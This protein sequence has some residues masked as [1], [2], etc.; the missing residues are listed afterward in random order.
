MDELARYYTQDKISQLLINKLENHSPKRI[1]ELG[2]GD[3]ALS[4]AAYK[5]WKKAQYFGIDIDEDSIASIKSKLPFI[6]IKKINGLDDDLQIK[7]D[8]ENSSID[9]AICNP[10]YL[11]H[12]E[13]VQDN[14][15]FEVTLLN[16][17]IT[18]KY[19]TTD[20]IFLAQNLQ[21]LKEGSELGII[22]PDSILTNQY[23]AELRK[24]LLFHHNVKCIIQLPDKV[25]NKTEAR[26]HILIIQKF[27]QG[28]SKIE[29]CNTDHNGIITDHIYVE[30]DKLIKRMDYSFWKYINYV[31]KR[32][33]IILEEIMSSL[34]RGNKTKK[35][36]QDM[37]INFFHTTSFSKYDN[38]ITTNSR[39]I[40]FKE[41]LTLAENGDILIARVGKR[42][43]GRVAI[44]TS[45][46]IPVSDC[47]YRLR[48][49][50]NFR[51]LVFESL[52]SQQGK[53]WFDAFSHGVCA[54][55]ISKS[56]LIKYKIYL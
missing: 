29:L 16:S 31:E 15:L 13:K 21:F 9:I 6:N 11:K 19:L 50:D 22:L 56:D 18:N 46:C 39:Q 30:R 51:E 54:R 36:L 40:D 41:N 32:K 43:I 8:I 49:P 3:G 38:H 24:D 35:E 7:L 1:L 5:R 34:T 47:I 27:C 20:I 26:T 52:I 37:N 55:V 33:Y 10:P 28:T 53:S 23:Y 17:C 2:I 42:C 25:F 14:K 12:R 44:V 48:V 4:L 45:G